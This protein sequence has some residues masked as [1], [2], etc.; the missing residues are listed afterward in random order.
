MNE[1]KE[2][3]EKKEDKEKSE[4][5]EEKEDKEKSEIKE[6]TKEKDDKDKNGI[7]EETKEKEDKDKNEDKDSNDE[8]EAKDKIVDIDSKDK[9]LN[10]KGVK[11]DTNI[12]EIDRL[13]LNK[14]D[15]RKSRSIMNIGKRRKL[16]GR[17]SLRVSNEMKGATNAIERSLQ[18][19]QRIKEEE[20]NRQKTQ[21]KKIAYE[22]MKKLKLFIYERK[23]AT[24]TNEE[25]FEENKK[26][27]E[28]Y[29]VNTYSELY[30][31]ITTYDR[32]NPKEA[33]K[34]E[35]EKYKK[36]LIIEHINNNDLSVCP[37]GKL[38]DN[39]SI[40][41]N[42][43]IN[44]IFIPISENHFYIF[45]IFKAYEYCY[46]PNREEYWNKKINA[47][48]IKNMNNEEYNG[49]KKTKFNNELELIES[50]N[51]SNIVLEKISKNEICSLD[52]YAEDGI[53]I[54]ILRNR[55]IEK[56][57]SNLSEEEK[58]NYEKVET[59]V[60]DLKNEDKNI[61]VEK[62]IFCID[63]NQCFK[64]ENNMEENGHNG[65]C[66][67]V[68]NND[69]E[70]YD[71]IENVNDLDYNANL[72]KLYD[73]LKKEQ[74]KIIKS[75]NRN[76]IKYY[77]KLLY[78]LYEIIINN[79]SIEELDTS[80]IEINDD[81]TKE[82]NSQTFN[83]FFKNYFY[84]YIKRIV[85]LTNLK[86]KK[87]E[88]LLADLEEDNGKTN[89]ETYLLDNGEDEDNPNNNIDKFNII[90]PKQSGN[91]DNI[92]INYD[93]LSE[94]DKKKY[95]INLGLKIKINYGKNVPIIEL[96]SKAKEANIDPNNYENF[97]MKELNISK[98]Q[99]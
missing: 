33:D 74:M 50:S 83:E 36:H 6:E 79:N 20:E 17:A 57:I 73:Y 76:L 56:M 98:T 60:G 66:I 55:K 89:T 84:F 8:E 21:E 19:H 3:T 27:F 48:Q 25:F 7:K 10:N 22:R 63:C 30:K 45:E 2:K 69:I 97:L 81:Y 67:L 31:L 65:H 62:D 23:D 16:R 11:Y 94:E 34:F 93:K 75:G 87:M 32:E 80:I 4:I 92:K 42:S 38:Y 43:G 95:F 47:Y 37:E 39:S 9:I 44:K 12:E 1:D 49:V 61:S 91:I 96:Y 90:S 53:P 77:G 59:I 5:K 29:E 99:N 26:Y 13:D 24:K 68:F 52:K 35:K 54:E 14:Y 58:N 88:Q 15:Y 41:I 72:N 28:Q 64:K 71:E 82:S 70:N 40:K 51:V 86:K 78:S 46:T 18:N 85:N